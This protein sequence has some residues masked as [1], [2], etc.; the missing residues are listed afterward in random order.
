MTFKEFDKLSIERQIE[1]VG[2]LIGKE[3]YSVLAKQFVKRL[4]V[5]SYIHG[6]NDAVKKL[7]K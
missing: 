2:S 5:N 3:N 7:K 4:S 1:Y 6:S